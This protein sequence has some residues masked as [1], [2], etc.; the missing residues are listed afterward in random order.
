M[1]TS[2]K[3]FKFLICF[4]IPVFFCF[5]TVNSKKASSAD[6]P[7][8]QAD[9]L[10]KR[11]TRGWNTWYT[12]SVTTHVLLPEGFAVKLMFKDGQTGDTLKEALI[13]RE[14]F[15]TREHVIPGLRSYD[16]SYTELEL[17]WR[18]IH[19]SIRSTA[20]NRD[21]DLLISPFNGS[22]NDSLIIVPTMLWN[23]NGRYSS[24]V[25]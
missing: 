24:S 11:L 7:G 16:G 6:D 25:I 17:E 15:A 2:K 12:G 21:L 3:S 18:N 22:R 4:L 14:N 20:S 19:I 1:R 10:Q 5:C 9:A 13:G 23:R 8:N